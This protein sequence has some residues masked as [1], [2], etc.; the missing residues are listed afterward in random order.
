MKKI[1]KTKDDKTIGFL[2]VFLA[3]ICWGSV[4]IPTKNL[5]NLGFDNYSISFFRSA[6]A[7]IFYL[8][9]C[10]IKNPKWLKVDFKGILFFIFYGIFVLSGCLLSFNIA[11][12]SLSIALGT[13]FLYTSQIWVVV[14]SYFMFKEKFTFNKIFAMILIFI[15]SSMMCG[16][17]SSSNFSLNAKG[18]IWGIIS[19]FT[20]ALQILLAKVSNDKYHSNT[21]LTYSFIFGTLILVPFMN[22]QNNISILSNTCNLSFILKNIAFGFVTTVI[23]NTSYVKSVQYI[24][25]SIASMISSSELIIASIVGFI[26][27]GETLSKLQI[28]GMIFILLS[29]VLLQIKKQNKKLE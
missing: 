2:L 5:A 1:I 20:F 27:F 13:M 22:M 23:A 10:L 18:V 3:S 15:G 19:G 8:L 7:A 28:L 6:P 21:L 29:I 26:I 14:L 16:I 24:E 9:Y 12:N 11:I 17:F 4:G 25:A